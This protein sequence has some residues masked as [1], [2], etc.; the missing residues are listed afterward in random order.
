MF[1]RSAWIQFAS[2]HS[3]S[4]SDDSQ[5][6]VLRQPS[7][8]ERE[9]A[10]LSPCLDTPSNERK[11]QRHPL[12]ADNP[13]TSVNDNLGEHYV[14]VSTSTYPKHSATRRKKAKP[15]HRH[16]NA[17]PPWSPPHP[18]CPSPTIL[19]PPDWHPSPF[20]RASSRSPRSSS[21]PV[22]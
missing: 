20:R 4:I 15:H 3:C 9:N 13:N 19:R 7:A 14:R 22:A 6:S 10:H 12:G 8:R 17:S 21:I 11:E 1:K 18:S 5:R 2:R 16:R